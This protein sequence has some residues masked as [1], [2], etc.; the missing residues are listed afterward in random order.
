MNVVRESLSTWAG[1]GSLK[2]VGWGV[3]C[4]HVTRRGVLTVSAPTCTPVRGED[5]SQK[6]KK[7]DVGHLGSP[8]CPAPPP[9]L[10]TTT[11]LGCKARAGICR[12]ELSLSFLKWRKSGYWPSPIPPICFRGFFRI[13]WNWRDLTQPFLSASTSISLLSPFFPCLFRNHL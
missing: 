5:V 6:V 1:E 8:P 12:A 4:H 7:E 3:R 9:P 11:T 13:A 2:L 10:S